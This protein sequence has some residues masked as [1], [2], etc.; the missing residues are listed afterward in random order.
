MFPVTLRRRLTAPGLA[1]RPRDL[2]VAGLA[3]VGAVAAGASGAEP[4]GTPGVDPALTGLVTA[5]VVVVSGRARRWSWLWGV[6][7]LALFAT[8]TAAIV[9]VTGA[10]AVAVVSI[11]LGVRRRDLGALAGLLLVLAALWLPTAGSF[12]APTVAAGLALG[13][14]VASGLLNGPSRYRRVAVR[15]AMVSGA[16]VLVGTV[17]L[18]VV[19]L[20]ARADAEEGVRQAQRALAALGDADADEAR[21]SLS[22]AAASFGQVE[23]TAGSWWAT[24]ARLVPIV[25]QHRAAIG[26]LAGAGR[27]LTETTARATAVADVEAIQVRGGVFDVEALAALEAPAGEGLAALRR[28]ERATARAQ[29][30]WLLTPLAGQVEDFGASV[31]GAIGPAELTLEGTRVVPDLLGRDRRRTYVVVFANP[32]EAREMGGFTG[33]VGLLT[34]DGGDLDFERVRRITP[35]NRELVAAGAR[36]VPGLPDAVAATQPERFVQNWTATPDSAVL[37]AIVSELWPLVAEAPADGVIYV[38]PIS[39]AGLL[40]LTGPVRVPELDAPMTADRVTEY[41]LRE[42]YALFEGDE[43]AEEADRKDIFADLA[44]ETFDR[45]TSGDLP[46]PRSLARTLG[47]AVAGRHLVFRPF[48]EAPRPLVRRVQLDGGLVRPEASDL[49]HV[50]TGNTRANKLDAYLTRTVEADVAIDGEGRLASTVTVSLRNA[51][52][53]DQLND[54]V[55]GTGGTPDGLA[56]GTNRMNLSVYSPWELRSVTVGGEPL[57]AGSQRVGSLWRHTAIVE[58]P[59]RSTVAVELEL[60]GQ[61]RPGE[62]YE[63]VVVPYAGAEDDDLAVRVVSPQRTAIPHPLQPHT[64][65]VEVRVPL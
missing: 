27:D 63:L 48:D 2:A 43:D 58:V 28:A 44:D 39:L 8:N 11:S 62:P 9:L 64:R 35:L 10:A 20:E 56:A 53:S 59:E 32:A 46:G 55:T 15:A 60:D 65:T 13:P 47:S 51:A 17:S 40:E 18:A 49:L 33:S 4:T 23:D 14:V 42:Q 1:V 12:G 19:V 45:L 7:V 3:T 16:V 34:A 61:W 29:S 21:I 22:L 25:S 57:P 6:G 30:G 41:L 31:A 24:P 54:Y 37:E 50:T 52:V 5:A 36:P 38:D 26:E